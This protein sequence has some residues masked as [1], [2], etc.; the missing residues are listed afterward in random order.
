MQRILVAVPHFFRRDKEGRH[1]SSRQSS[2]YRR[3]ALLTALSCLRQ[4][5]GPAQCSLNIESRSAEPVNAPFRSDTRIIVCT[6]AGEHLLDGGVL[7]MGG[8]EHRETNSDPKMLGFV[9]H[10][11]LA[12]NLGRFDWYCYLEDDLC[13]HDPLFFTKLSWFTTMLDDDCLLMPN[14]FET[15]VAGPVDKAYIDGDLAARVTRPFQDVSDRRKVR[16]R[17]MGRELTFVRP[18]N[19]HSG[20]FFLNSRQMEHWA[21]RPWFM[22]RET[23]FIGPLESAATLGVMRAFRVYKPAMQNPGFLEVQHWGRSFLTLIGNTVRPLRFG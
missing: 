11:V 15:A 14:R 16:G 5:F 1:G 10:Q 9:C 12:E 6:T 21:G 23:S 4:H 8:V 22:D 3:G 13:I 18:L 7:G 2:E 17:V 19:P 20:C